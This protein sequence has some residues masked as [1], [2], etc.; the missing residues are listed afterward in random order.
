MTH[1]GAGTLLKDPNAPRD[2]EPN[3]WNAFPDDEIAPAHDERM[4]VF[5]HFG[6]ND[7]HAD[8]YL[9]YLKTR[10]YIVNGWRKHPFTP[11][12]LAELAAG[13]LTVRDMPSE[14]MDDKRAG[15]NEKW[16]PFW[17]PGIAAPEPQVIE[18]VVEVPAKT[19]YV[20]RAPYSAPQR[21]G[22]F[23]RYGRATKRRLT[24]VLKGARQGWQDAE[25]KARKE[26]R[27]A[28]QKSGPAS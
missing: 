28:G 11:E 6:A 24:G 1:S 27:A 8:R 14:V 15:L 12:V 19:V 21:Q 18:K 5:V 13:G 3:E 17:Y 10:T 4:A 20:E 22:F 23:K 7:K 26:A 9:D 25:P 2:P 16:Q